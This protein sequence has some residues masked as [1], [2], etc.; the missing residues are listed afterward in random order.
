MAR[1]P[2]DRYVSAREL[3]DELRRFQT[4]KLLASRTY[5]R[6][7]LVR[8]FIK[9]NRGPLVV[10]AAALV[11]LIGLS[12]V[13]VANIRAQRDRA[14]LHRLEAERALRRAQ[15]VLAS[16]LAAEAPRRLEALALGLRAVGPELIGQA[17]GEP[18]H[19]ATQGLLDA[20]AA[21]PAPRPLLH[22]GAVTDFDLSPDGTLLAGAGDD[23]TILLWDA[24]TG[25]ER[26]RARSTLADP[27][28][29][30]F[31]P[32]GKRVVVCGNNPRG[33]LHDLGGGPVRRFDLGSAP[34]GC[35]FLPDGTLVA[36]TA[37][38]LLLDPATGQVKERSPLPAHAVY[39]S[40][41]QD[42]GHLALA[43]VD[44]SVWVRAPGSTLQ[45]VAG[46][47]A[48]ATSLTINRDG[49]ALAF[50]RRDGSIRA[51]QHTGDTWRE[52][53]RLDDDPSRASASRARFSPDGQ[54][55]SVPLWSEEEVVTHTLLAPSGRHLA[56]AAVFAQDWD[57]HGRFFADAH[58]VFVLLDAR[59][60]LPVLSLSGHTDEVKSAAALTDGAA[61][62]S[63]DGADYLWDLREGISSGLLL[64]HTSEITLA[65]TDAA[66]KRAITGGLDG[67]LRVWD[68]TTGASLA[69]QR[70]GSGVTRAAFSSDGRSVFVGR[71]DGT[72]TRFD[73][74][75]SASS[76]LWS[77]GAPI[78][79]LTL[80]AG[81]ELLAASF[82]GAM[83]LFHLEGAGDRGVG[84]E[85]AGIDGA[86][87]TG[88]RAGFGTP[89]TA[90]L[91]AAASPHGQVIISAGA[92]GSVIAWDARSR[93]RLASAAAPGFD[94]GP[95]GHM[96]VV[97]LDD[98]RVLFGRPGGE[99][100]L[101]D[102]RT[103]A[104]LR[105]LP[106][107]PASPTRSPLS[108]DGRL[109]AAANSSG[110]V[111]VHDLVKETSERLP[112]GGVVL[113][114]DFSADGAWLATGDL[115]GVVRLYDLRH[116]APDRHPQLE[117]RSPLGAATAVALPADPRYVLAGFHSGA[118][119]LH[120][121]DART[122][123]ER[124]CASLRRFELTSLAAPY[125]D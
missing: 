53:A 93:Q 88:A 23:K 57:A 89:G 56:S 10:A 72:L 38:L 22:P 114:T 60:G 106:G 63:R 42:T 16:R 62:A 125:C 19:E 7:E 4:G 69:E 51:L 104:T 119:R 34:A 49:S 102:A 99:T 2:R 109:F 61:S 55:V 8:H 79:A 37:D 59:D 18:S 81:G 87:V 118:L 33:E 90:I 103:L 29:V 54:T 67:T 47:G 76:T 39:L 12:I 20:L 40:I 44:G 92:D 31:E 3:A 27:H 121:R 52:T 96:A 83:A 15:G 25:A 36:A 41:A 105:T 70:G 115:D 123:F 30:R 9:R 95:E 6:A 45:R 107:R 97:F 66:R 74:A 91:A 28:F 32:D 43:L 21:G 5:T 14:E 84:V 26:M 120:P 112:D 94:E 1:D 113:S 116:L 64:G 117:L 11:I 24:H 111:T 101:A 68:L 86:G 110:G 73:P 122:A 78:S 82:S 98:D 65:L 50:A 77:A 124:A 75:T 48:V 80:V 108:A 46:V 58:G 35:L 85:G 100:L 13:G 71:L 17:P